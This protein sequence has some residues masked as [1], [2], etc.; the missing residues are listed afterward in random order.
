MRNK[1]LV[2]MLLAVPLVLASSAYADLISIALQ[3]P[4][5]AFNAKTTVATG[6]GNVVF[7]GSYGTWTVNDV[8]A[9]DFTI[10]GPNNLLHSNTQDIS[11]STAGVLTVWVTA[12]G[13]S[14]AGLTNFLSSFAVNTLTG[15]I[16]SVSLTTYFDAT[17]ALYTGTVLNSHAFTGVGSAGPFSNLG[18]PGLLYSVTEQYQI[19]DTGGGTVSN[20]NLTADLNKAIVPEP[21]SL[22]LLGAGLLGIALKLRR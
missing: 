20:D 6:S 15:S 4:S 19:F 14:A 16:V 1:M 10:L 7:S 2:M 13:L 22:G 5:V 18:T 9:T 12:Q 3:E 17:N 11:S 8:T 21:A